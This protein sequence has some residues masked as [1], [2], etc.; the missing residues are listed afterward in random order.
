M[1]GT[2]LIVDGDVNAQIIVATL[3]RLRGFT[4][5]VALDVAAA[6]ET[7]AHDHVG[8]VLVDLSALGMNSLETLHRLRTAYAPLRVPRRIVAVTDRDPASERFARQVGADAIL[9][10][11]MNPGQLIATVEELV[12]RSAPQAA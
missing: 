3:L 7:F 2:V 4:V 1:N 5:R 8:V 11:P 10:K 6:C 12:E 9:R